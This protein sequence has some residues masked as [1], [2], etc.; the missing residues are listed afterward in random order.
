MRVARGPQKDSSTMNNGHAERRHE[1]AG[2][3]PS[4]PGFLI[5]GTQKAGTTASVGSSFLYARVLAAVPTISSPR[6]LC[7]W[8]DRGRA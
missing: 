3:D 5:I 4:L 1:Q 2:R 6:S 7:V 8:I